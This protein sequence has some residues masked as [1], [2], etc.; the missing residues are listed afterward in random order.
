MNLIIQILILIDYIEIS[1]KN[2]CDNFSKN[3]NNWAIQ[4]FPSLRVQFPNNV[5]VFEFHKDSDYSHHIGEINNFLAVTNCK[6]TSALH[7]QKNLGW[8]DYEPFNL[9]SGELAQINTSIFKH[10]DLKNCENFTRISIDFRVIPLS[11]IKRAPVGKRITAN[12]KMD[13]NN[14][15]YSYKIKK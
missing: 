13:E 8:E 11:V 15:Y 5:S 12:K 6:N 1:P 4:R 2:I 10:G 3:H 14:Y 7:I 9:I